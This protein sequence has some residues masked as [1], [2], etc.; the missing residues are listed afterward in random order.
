MQNTQTSY[1]LVGIVDHNS[2]ITT[3]SHLYVKE[4]MTWESEQ[5]NNI[6]T[7]CAVG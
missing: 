5:P 7:A 1:V 6:Q 3:G 4:K 2:V